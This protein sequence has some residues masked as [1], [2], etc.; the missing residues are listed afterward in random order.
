MSRYI[1]SNSAYGSGYTRSGLSQVRQPLSTAM[2]IEQPLRDYP[3]N[4]GNR[5][6]DRT[7][8]SPPAKRNAHSP[9]AIDDGRP[10]GL[11]NLRNTCYINSVLQLLFEILEVPADD[12][13]KPVSKAYM[14][15]RNTHSE[16]DLCSLKQL[17][18]KDLLFV[19]GNHQQDA[20]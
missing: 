18:E 14:H 12:R 20:Q 2:Q 6:P 5:R 15:L 10:R 3:T 13:A 9:P 8:V 16:S 19:R 4:N 1:T 7:A 17:L 11:A